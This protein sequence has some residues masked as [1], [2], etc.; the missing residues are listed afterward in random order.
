VEFALRE[1]GYRVVTK[2]A[3]LPDF[4]TNALFVGSE[5]PVAD[6][7]IIALALLRSGA[8][9]QRVCNFRNPG[10]R[11]RVVQ[12]GSSAAARRAPVLDVKALESLTAASLRCGSGAS[13]SSIPSLSS[14]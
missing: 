5:V 2:P 4:V 10:T 14:P 8:E 13:T 9:L 12:V 7:R 1:L 3:E 11:P 6:V